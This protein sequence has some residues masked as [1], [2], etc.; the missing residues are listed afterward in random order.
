MKRRVIRLKRKASVRRKS[1]K[2]KEK[3]KTDLVGTQLMSPLGH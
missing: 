2:L 1:H 3:Q